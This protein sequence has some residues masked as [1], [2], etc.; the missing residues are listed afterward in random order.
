MDRI[1]NLESLI[2]RH[3]RNCDW[4]HAD[5]LGGLGGDAWIGN[6]LD[7]TAILDAGSTI[8]DRMGE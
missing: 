7:Y 6:D 4:N 2:G 3:H 5:D 1:D 8:A